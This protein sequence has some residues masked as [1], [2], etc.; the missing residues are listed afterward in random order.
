MNSPLDER[1][2]VPNRPISTTSPATPSPWMNSP[3]AMGR[4]QI[5][6]MPA[7]MLASVPCSARATA[8]PAAPS[9]ARIDV[10]ATPT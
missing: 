1:S 3:T 4:S 2:C 8:R 7:A 10:L 6:M 9:T 5:N